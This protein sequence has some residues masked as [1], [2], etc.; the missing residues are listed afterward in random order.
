MEISWLQSNILGN[1]LSKSAV[2]VVYNNFIIN[3]L[4]NSVVNDGL[5]SK[6]YD[7]AYTADA[8]GLRIKSLIQQK[9]EKHLSK[10]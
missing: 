9:I 1:I 10:F 3:I 2:P 4:S 8:K 7:Y 6:L 5:C